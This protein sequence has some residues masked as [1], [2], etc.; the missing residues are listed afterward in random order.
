VFVAVIAL[1]AAV[2]LGV[3]APA[4]TAAADVTGWDA[5]NIISDEVFYASQ[6][7]TG[8]QIQSFLQGQVSSCQSGYTCLKDYVVS[9]PDV[10]ANSYCSA[11]KGWSAQRAAD[12]IHDVA[13]A[14][15]INPQVLLV[16]LQKEQGLIT[17]TH[18]TNTM[19][20]RALGFGCP[21]S[22]GGW[23]DPNYGSLF[24]QVYAAARQF[25]I[26]RAYPTSFNFVAG[27]NNTIT[28]GPGCAKSSSV[29]IQNQATAGLYDYTPY[30]PD[31]RVL[32]AGFGSIGTTDS[33]AAYGNRNFYL[34][35]NQWFGSTRYNVG[36]AI[37]AEWD[38]LGGGEGVLGMPQ[39]DE[40][41]GLTDGG[42]YQY[43]QNGQIH[44]TNSTGAHATYG[45]IKTEWGVTGWE[46][47][48]LGYP[49]NDAYCGLANDGC[50][51]GFQG[52][53][54]HWT[55]S[56]GAHF[57]HGAI[58]A[59]WAGLGWE[60]G[61][62]G[63]PTTDEICGLKDGGCYQYFENG[64][65]H[66]TAATGAHATSGVIKD[67]WGATGWENGF[68][69]YPVADQNC[70]LADHGCSQAFQGG[71]IHW[72]EA[73]GAQWTRGGIQSDWA[74]LGWENGVL[75]YPTTGENCGLKDG[76]CF[77]YFQGGQIHWSPATGA[78]ATYG[79]IKQAWG[80]TG[81]ETG[82]LGYPTSDEQCSAD[83][84]SCWQTFQGGTI[85]LSANGTTQLV[86][87]AAQAAWKAAGGPTGTMGIATAAVKCDGSVCSQQFSSGE[88]V[89]QS[90]ATTAYA[91]NAAFATAWSS[92]GGASGSLG[93]PTSTM[94]C[95]LKDNGCFQHFQGGDM[96]WT[97][98]TG[99]Q[100][101]VG[102]IHYLWG[103]LGFENGVLGYPLAAEQCNSA[104]NTCTQK[105]QGG[106]IIWTSAGGAKLG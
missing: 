22:S 94:G 37:G 28:Y 23:C 100:P 33:C 54:I 79:A 102:G 41:C 31:S 103:Q 75:G 8:D 82:Q 58:Q 32:A 59:E 91:L 10:A 36:G 70:N 24:S 104:H 2:F 45:A 16:T 74:S 49:I 50:A 21:D 57:T 52:G 18:P 84:S 67:A 62:L 1:I 5:G 73:T 56:T 42:C 64:Q 106:S 86:T 98:G 87:G 61:S 83:K 17:S 7:M 76:G 38:A 9:T 35:F 96:H 11:Y 30:Q 26:Y 47:G 34:Y 80:K 85:T 39:T 48:T 71:Q 78:H 72:T 46:T 14:C 12:M 93:M 53:Q 105:F 77:Q 44:W 81:W 101:T 66:S 13:I 89:W 19:Y 92:D 97:S 20:I 90:G 68:L 27:R 99:A 60:T 3:S 51:Q 40:I 95:G 88:I 69:G 65:I 63:Y 4:Q 55:N 43:F 25:K 6:T 15:G 29:Y